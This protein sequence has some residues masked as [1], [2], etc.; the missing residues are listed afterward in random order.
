MWTE[1]KLDSLLTTPS[2]AMIE[3]IKKID[4]DIMVLGAGGKMGP[5]LC[6]MTKRAIDA[7]GIEWLSS[8]VVI[9]GI[10]YWDL[11]AQVVATETVT[12]R[13]NGVEK[14][15]AILHRLQLSGE[16]DEGKIS[17]GADMYF[18]AI[19]GFCSSS[20]LPPWYETPQPNPTEP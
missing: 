13:E 16:N 10:A 2:S 1:E 17:T 11:H 18:E 7:A 19:T 5:T 15:A 8:D 20:Y 4:G 9:H 6:L 3:D 12:Y 14:T